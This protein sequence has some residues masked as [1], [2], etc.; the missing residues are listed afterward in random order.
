MR[1]M[2]EKELWEAVHSKEKYVF[3][4]TQKTKADHNAMFISDNIIEKVT[5]L[6]KRQ[7]KTSGYMADQV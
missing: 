1:Q 2:A 4:K 6:K 5:T 3:S 7:A